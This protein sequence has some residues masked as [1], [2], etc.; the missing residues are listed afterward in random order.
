MNNIEATTL[1]IFLSEFDRERD[2]FEV[3]DRIVFNDDDSV[4]V[5]GRY[6]DWEGW[7]LVEQLQD[8]RWQLMELKRI[9]SEE[10]I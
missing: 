9:D 1:G 5:R 7:F 4:V 8:I 6:S 10:D 2:F 3:L